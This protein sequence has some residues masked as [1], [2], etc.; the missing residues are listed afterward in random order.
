V[1]IMGERWN[2]KLRKLREM[3]V[4]KARP[5]KVEPKR[6]RWSDPV[7]P[8][9]WYSV[10]GQQRITGQCAMCHEYQ[11]EGSPALRRGMCGVCYMRTLDADD[12]A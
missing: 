5:V 11:I 2:E 1:R 8:S 9:D 12:A 7:I 3:L 10:T 6:R 4:G